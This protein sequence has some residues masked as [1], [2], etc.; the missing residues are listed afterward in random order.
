M[1]YLNDQWK[2]VFKLKQGPREKENPLDKAETNK[3]DIKKA[4]LDNK[5][6]QSISKSEKQNTENVYPGD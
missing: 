6:I 2:N 4:S 1:Q 5:W 3:D